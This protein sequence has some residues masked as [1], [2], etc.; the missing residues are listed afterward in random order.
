MFRTSLRRNLTI[1]GAM[2]GIASLFYYLF[3]TSKIPPDSSLVKA[4]ALP[5]T[6]V[7][8]PLLRLFPW[9]FALTFLALPL[10]ALVGVAIG[11]AGAV[12]IEKLASLFRAQPSS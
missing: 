8:E 10:T 2:W 11:Y 9:A 1:L 5:A 6:I 4:I 7:L 12:I 3:S